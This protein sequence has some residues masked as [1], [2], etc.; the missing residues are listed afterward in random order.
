VMAG[1]CFSALPRP[2]TH[3]WPPAPTRPGT[4]PIP[5][6]WRP[7][8]LRFPGSAGKPPAALPLLSR[9]ISVG[10]AN[11][12]ARA[13]AAPTEPGRLRRIAAAPT[14]LAHHLEGGPR[15]PRLFRVDHESQG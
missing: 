5:A 7:G 8:F 13:A 3:Q 11:E 14:L 6:N 1:I 10:G 4:D 9:E 12:G 15:P 2:A